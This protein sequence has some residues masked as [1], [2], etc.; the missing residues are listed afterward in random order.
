M[1]EYELME[2]SEPDFFTLISTAF[3]KPDLSNHNA[4]T[5]IKALTNKTAESVLTN[6]LR[7]VLGASAAA[8]TAKTS[9]LAM[10]KLAISIS[11]VSTNSP[12]LLQASFAN[13]APMCAP[14][15]KVTARPMAIGSVAV[16]T[17]A[18]ACP[19]CDVGRS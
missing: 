10:R 5:Q 13:F 9:R 15:A 14:T 8:S 4:R 3:T 6:S 7:A 2:L 11:Q 12:P 18:N 1:E 17:N 19:R 16:S